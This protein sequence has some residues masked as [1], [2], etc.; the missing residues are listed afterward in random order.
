MKTLLSLISLITAAGFPCLA[1]AELAGARLPASVNAETALA[2]F[3]TSSL[4]LIAL[5]DYTRRFKTL[6]PA[7]ERPLRPSLRV[8]QPACRP[9]ARLAA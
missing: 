2:V 1:F 6:A 3:A 8:D 4:L 7:V 5:F 9:P